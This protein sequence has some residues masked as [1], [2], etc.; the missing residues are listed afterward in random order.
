MSLCVVSRGAPRWPDI[1]VDSVFSKVKGGRGGYTEAAY[2]MMELKTQV[3][4]D[5]SSLVEW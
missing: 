1:E 5:V 3:G 2:V 4:K